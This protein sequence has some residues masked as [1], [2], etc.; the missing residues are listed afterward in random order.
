MQPLPEDGGRTGCG[1]GRPCLGVGIPGHL[2]A[3]GNVPEPRRWVAPWATHLRPAALVLRGPTARERDPL[4]ILEPWM[5]V[6][7]FQFQGWHASTTIS[8]VKNYYAPGARPPTEL[9]PRYEGRLR[10]G[11]TRGTRLRA[12]TWEPKGSISCRWGGRRP[13]RTIRVV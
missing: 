2:V 7:P 8:I 10:V 1:A 12:Y 11:P 9:M 4:T 5:C 13:H 3:G 6:A